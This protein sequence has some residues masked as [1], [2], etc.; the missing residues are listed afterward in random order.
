MK[1][2]PCVLTIAGSDS[3]GGAG[4]QAD[5]KAISMAG[6]YGASA[7]TALTAQNTTGVTGIEAVSPEFVALQIETVCSDIKVCA[8]KTGMLFPLPSS[9][10]LA[11]PSKIKTFRWLLIRYALQPVEPSC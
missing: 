2:L 5:L 3:G 7:I 9:E 6:C 4:I 10:L 11:K 8:A 1:P